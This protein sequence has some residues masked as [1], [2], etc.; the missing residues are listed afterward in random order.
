M[1]NGTLLELPNKSFGP[2]VITD[3]L[4]EFMTENKDQPFLAYYPMILPHNPFVP[5][6]DSKNPQSKDAKQNFIDMV[7]YIDTCVGRIEDAL[8]ELGIRDNTLIVFTGDNGTNESISSAWGEGQ[9]R[10]GKG[11]TR[12]HGTHCLLYTSPSPRDQRGSRMP[13][14]A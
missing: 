10:G 13:S 4:I 1:Q 14:S 7:Q 3:F 11:Y 2:T 5:T 9:L 6:P 12:D 8:I